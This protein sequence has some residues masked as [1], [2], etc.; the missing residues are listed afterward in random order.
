MKARSGDIFV[1]V[2]TP[3][4]A[5]R[6]WLFTPATRPDRFPTA[7]ASG[8]DVTILDLEDSVA[9]GDKDRARET[10]LG[11]LLA[12]KPGRIRHALRIN[13]LDTQAGLRDLTAVL[14]SKAVPD[15]LV[16]PKT[17]TAGHLLILDRLLTAASRPIKLIGL[18]ESARGLAAVE[19]IAAATPR[20]AG[21]MIGAADMAAERAWPDRSL[22][23]VRSGP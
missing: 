12:A 9:L 23:S 14:G 21:L 7:A 5:T 3:L 17:E 4:S 18:I 11:F 19:A 2:D 8:A 15:F 13:G 1:M 16:L 22:Q 6:S 20:L 10:A